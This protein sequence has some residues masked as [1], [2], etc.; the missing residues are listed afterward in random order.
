[1]KC[2]SQLFGLHNPECETTATTTHSAIIAFKLCCPSSASEQ[3]ISMAVQKVKSWDRFSDLK[4]LFR[5]RIS[6]ETAMLPNC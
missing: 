5:S 2:H 3:F 6:S 1:M 4:Y